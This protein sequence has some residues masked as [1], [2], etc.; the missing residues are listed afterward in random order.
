MMVKLFAFKTSWSQLF[1]FCRDRRVISDGSRQ[2]RS[3]RKRWNVK[4]EKI[5]KITNF[6]E[7][8]PLRKLTYCTSLKCQDWCIKKEFEFNCKNVHSWKI[9]G[10]FVVS[11]QIIT[12]YIIE[13]LN[14]DKCLWKTM[15]KTYSLCGKRN[16]DI[17]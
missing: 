3:S 5:V 4:S 9:V 13:V 2:S 17:I 7:I 14:H 1:D 8:I 10:V 12:I 6:C 16:F 11:K 15:Q